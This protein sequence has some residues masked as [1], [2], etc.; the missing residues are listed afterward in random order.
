M[1]VINSSVTIGL[2]RRLQSHLSPFG[3]YKIMLIPSREGAGFSA[4]LAHLDHLRTTVT[5]NTKSFRIKDLNS[6]IRNALSTN[7][8]GANSTRPPERQVAIG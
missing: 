8:L 3:S 4:N 6:F 2:D 1:V 5:V 7:E